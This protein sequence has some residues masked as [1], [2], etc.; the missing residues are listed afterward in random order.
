MGGNN[1]KNMHAA[2]HRTSKDRRLL[3]VLVQRKYYSNIYCHDFDPSD[4]TK[5]VIV[6][7]LFYIFKALPLQ[8]GKFI[9]ATK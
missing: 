6:F 9:K 5:S 1:G 3:I 8:L 2:V 7:F 4:V